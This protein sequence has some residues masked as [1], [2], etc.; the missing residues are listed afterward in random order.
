M[1]ARVS[2]HTGRMRSAARRFSGPASRATPNRDAGYR[3]R[4]PGQSEAECPSERSES[5]D[6]L[7]LFLRMAPSPCWTSSHSILLG[8]Y[9]LVQQLLGPLQHSQPALRQILPRAVHIE[10]QHPH[11]RPWPF[12]RNL[13]RSEAARNRRRILLEQPLLR[14]GRFG[15]HSRRPLPLSMRATVR[16]TTRPSPRTPCCAARSFCRRTLRTCCPCCRSSRHISLL[17]FRCGSEPEAFHLH[18]AVRVVTA[19]SRLTGNVRQFATVLMDIV[20]PGCSCRLFSRNAPRPKNPS[21]N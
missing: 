10:R 2:E 5:R 11:P 18:G 20:R 12:R 15:V 4:H 14:I 8:L 17:F 6:S 19:C 1:D 13:L 16:S 7:F 3:I 21:A 9:T